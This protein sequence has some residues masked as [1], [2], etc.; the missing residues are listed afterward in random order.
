MSDFIKAE[1]I[2]LGELFQEVRG[3][4]IPDYQRAYTWNKVNISRLINDT[5]LD[6]IVQLK[7]YDFPNFL[8]AILSIDTSW[9]E[10]EKSFNLKETE[11]PSKVHILIDGQQRIT[12]LILITSVLYKKFLQYENKYKD[13]DI[14]SEYE[15]IETILNTQNNRCMEILFSKNASKKATD[16]DQTNLFLPKIIYGYTDDKWA[17][18]QIGVYKHPISAFL[19]KLATNTETKIVDDEEIQIEHILKT[20]ESY[21]ESRELSSENDDSEE[22]ELADNN[23]TV[24]KIIHLLLVDRGFQK[25]ALGYELSD[26]LTNFLKMQNEESFLAQKDTINFLFYTTILEFL[27]KRI[28]FALIQVNAETLA[29]DIF[30][31]LNS[32]GDSLTSFETFKPIV[33]KTFKSENKSYSSSNEKIWLEETS[34]YLNS[35]KKDRHII[36]KKYITNYLY[37][38][39]G[40]FCEERVDSQRKELKNLFDSMETSDQRKKIIQDFDLLNQLYKNLWD[41]KCTEFDGFSEV[42]KLGISVFKKAQHTLVIPILAYYYEEFIYK[43]KDNEDK[44]AF[45][46]ILE[47]LFAFSLLWRLLSNGGT[48]GIDDVYKSLILDLCEH[49]NLKG[50]AKPVELVFEYLKTILKEKKFPSSK[51]TAKTIIQSIQ[52]SQYSNNSKNIWIKFFIYISYHDAIPDPKDPGLCIKGAKGSNNLL[53]IRI[54]ENQVSPLTLEHIAP[55]RPEDNS[56]EPELFYPTNLH[57]IGNLIPIPKKL[58]SQLGNKSWDEKK[59][60]YKAISEKN[61][62]KRKQIIEGLL[63]NKLK[64]IS[65]SD[66]NFNQIV[67]SEYLSTLESLTEVDTWSPDFVKKRAHQIATLAWE[68]ISPWLGYPPR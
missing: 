17:R 3:F 50:S 64:F 37:F 42:S 8:G 21:L 40:K 52:E 56:W 11:S 9:N 39:T 30:D 41:V 29:F 43:K 23:E 16:P 48:A 59:I 33:I 6:G 47:G 19:Y 31:S 2:S 15:E 1:G 28:N 18:K 45:S 38:T 12:T 24:S 60:I 20:I 62:N 5:I 63:A 34:N 13:N 53:D 68:N 61:L 44:A 49:R 32:T 14:L 7:K 27:L 54:W 55:Q 26:Q 57:S 58:N 46:K 65:Q 25:R 66:K 4:F 35:K 10:L 51:N 22:D 67:N 36:T